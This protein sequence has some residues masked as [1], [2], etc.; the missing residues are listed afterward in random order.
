MSGQDVASDPIAPEFSRPV[1]VERLDGKM[2][3]ERLEATEEERRAVA[4]RLGLDALE[5]LTAE[6][7]L[8]LL[9]HGDFVRAEGRFSARVRQ[10]CSVTLAPVVSTLEESFSRTYGFVD[11]E[12]AKPGQE[13]ELEPEGEE[14]PDPILEGMVDLGE[15]VVEELSLAVDPFPRADGAVFDA[16]AAG[17]A[18]DKENPFAVL[19][20][21]RKDNG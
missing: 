13:I 20:K 19:A 9:A 7:R 14:P 10:T 1:D 17:V 12:E 2:R 6:V 4:G 16:A 8:S 11:V 18:E 5:A 3:V 21:L 15:L